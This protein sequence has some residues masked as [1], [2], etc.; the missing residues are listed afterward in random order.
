MP[1]TVHYI[2]EYRDYASYD[3]QAEAIEAEATQIRMFL[4]LSPK[5]RRKLL[6]NNDATSQIKEWLEDIVQD[7][8][9]LH[10]NI[11]AD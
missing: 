2:H 4:A 8:S 6:S 9:R 7:A 11:D 3:Q 1:A 10:R 5:Q